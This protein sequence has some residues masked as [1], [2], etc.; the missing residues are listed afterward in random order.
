MSK[1][2]NTHVDL[3]TEQIPYLSFL[4]AMD[5]RK[6][7]KELL[8]RREASRR[9]GPINI[10]TWEK[11]G[12]LRQRDTPAGPRFILSE[13]LHIAAGMPVVNDLTNEND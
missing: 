8:S 4:E 13:L 7:D 11:D 1:F 5:M 6:A 10:T 3:N 2:F 9:F 12:L